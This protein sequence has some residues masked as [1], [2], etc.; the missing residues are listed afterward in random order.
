VKGLVNINNGNALKEILS[1][2]RECDYK[3]HFKVLESVDFGIP[4]A[5]ERVYLVGIRNDLYDQEFFFPQ[6]IEKAIEIKSFLID[7]DENFGR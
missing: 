7:E 2:L 4:Q 5:R 3:V 1:L 6:P